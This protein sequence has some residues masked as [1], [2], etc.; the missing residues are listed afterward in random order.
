MRR[1]KFLTD[2]IRFDESELNLSP[3]Q[4]KEEVRK[5]LNSVPGLRNIPDTYVDPNTIGQG[6]LGTGL[7][8]PRPNIEQNYQNQQTP[9]GK[10]LLVNVQLFS[11]F[12]LEYNNSNV[13]GIGQFLKSF[14]VIRT[15]SPTSVKDCSNMLGNL[16]RNITGITEET[17]KNGTFQHPSYIN[18]NGTPLVIRYAEIGIITQRTPGRLDNIPLSYPD[19]DSTPDGIITSVG[20]IPGPPYTRFLT[21]TGATFPIQIQQGGTV[22]FVD[23]TPQTPWQFAPT[24]WVWDFGATASPSGSTA[25]NPPIVTYATSGTFSVTLTTSNSSG[26]RSETNF[27]IVT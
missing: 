1:R 12:F 7:F 6:L 19:F 14:A 4:K 25:Q 17:Y 9:K 20:P 22:F 15:L 10:P 21:A 5:V 16:A 2:A 18:D 3:R 27:V 26:S 11:L 13:K 8:K 23:A 24:G